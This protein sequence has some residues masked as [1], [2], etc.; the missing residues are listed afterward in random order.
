MSATG[1][2]ARGSSSIHLVPFLGHHVYIPN[3]NK[4]IIKISALPF[5]ILSVGQ[6]MY[7]SSDMADSGKVNITIIWGMTYIHSGVS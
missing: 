4:E 7:F 3:A 1:D 6:I 2:W 5:S